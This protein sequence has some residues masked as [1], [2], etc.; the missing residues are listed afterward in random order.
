[1]GFTLFAMAEGE[2]NDEIAYSVQKI[3]PEQEVHATSPFYDLGVKP[4][5]KR[6]IE[7]KISNSGEKTIE[8]KSQIF[9][10]YTTENGEIAYTNQAK[11]YDSSLQYK[12][13]DIA[14]I[15]ASDIKSTIPPKSQKIVKVEI[16]VPENTKD[17]V[18][19]GSWY[20]EKV[21]NEDNQKQKKSVNI[22]NRYSYA[23]PIKLT[24]NKEVDQPNLN[25]D[26]VTIGL[27]NYKKTF[28]A[29]LINDQPAIISQ[30]SI[31]AQVMKKGKYDVL[32]ENKTDGLIMAPNSN[33]GYPVYL[34]K[35]T[36]KP[37]DYTM[38]VKATTTDP[39]WSKKT[40]TWSMDF[41]ILNE[42]SKK[43]NKEAIN[44]PEPEKSMLGW[45]LAIIVLVILVLI[46]IFFLIF[47]RRKKDEENLDVQK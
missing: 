17:G 5:D 44:D 21:V 35:G 26:S 27:S 14:E 9:A 46:L 43:L 29:N 32:Y 18:L 16:N 23:L 6:V 19:L 25:L 45:I 30:L 34:G 39:K 41:T 11:E 12:M 38:K 40:W 47:K 13:N 42:E 10:C 28:F 1:M 36:F 4:G 24:V 22:G 33:F 37:G 31:E 15:R 7:A 2:E 20:F 3:A 8:V